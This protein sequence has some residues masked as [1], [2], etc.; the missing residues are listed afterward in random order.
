MQETHV[1]KMQPRRPTCTDLSAIHDSAPHTRTSAI[2]LR[3]NR[4]V[5]WTRSNR[6]LIRTARH[7]CAPTMQLSKRA[8][9]PTMHMQRF[10]RGTCGG[11]RS[12][13]KRSI[14]PEPAAGFA[15]RLRGRFANRCLPG[16]KN[17]D[18]RRRNHRLWSPVGLRPDGA[19]SSALQGGLGG[20]PSLCM[21]LII[22]SR[23]VF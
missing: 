15:N 13:F 14:D 3:S 12:A 16:Y 22:H 21:H 19:K 18:R 4:S 8:F 10:D 1:R 20:G 5:R 2:G 11:W 23:K 6:I 9:V 7:T 17:E